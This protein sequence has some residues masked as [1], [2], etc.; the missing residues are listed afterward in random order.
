MSE[1]RTSS[2]LRR[3]LGM[4]P[5]ARELEIE[6]A[7]WRGRCDRADQVVL[8]AEQRVAAAEYL[9]EQAEADAQAAEALV[10]KIKG[11]LFDRVNEPDRVEG[12]EKIRFHH[13]EPA[14]DFMLWL[15]REAQEDPQF[16]LT[17]QCKVCPRSPVTLQRYWH[18][19][20]DDSVDAQ[21]E[22][23][24]GMRRRGRQRAEARRAGRLVEQRIDPA[25][26]AKL[27]ALKDATARRGR[28]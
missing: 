24:L 16:W 8:V 17:Y 2:R 25:A 6:L 12:C 19:A 3:W 23:A 13:Q 9:A 7:V 10:E 21:H 22:K 1:V 26:V 15:C 14:H 4:G 28:A 18:V 20:H 27:L 11:E 5:S